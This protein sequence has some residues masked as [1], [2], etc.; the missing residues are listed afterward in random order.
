MIAQQNRKLVLDF[1]TQMLNSHDLMSI[2]Q[3]LSPDFI[4]H[5]PFPGTT[6]DAAG[7]EL[8]LTILFIAYYDLK[9][10]LD[11]CNVQGDTVI[12][13]WTAEASHPGGLIGKKGVTIMTGRKLRWTGTTTARLRDERI[14]ELWTC[15]DE[16]SLL[17]Q[18]S[19]MPLVMTPN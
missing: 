7:Y 10:T 5:T 3:F 16:K 11:E 15:Q 18:L 12:A 8:G 19:E 2:G 4:H 13:R 6:N 1:F 14:E 9:Y 17:A